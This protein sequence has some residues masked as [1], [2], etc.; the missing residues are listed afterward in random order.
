MWAI[1]TVDSTD[2]FNERLD[3]ANEGLNLHDVTFYDNWDE[4]KKQYKAVAGSISNVYL[5]KVIDK[6]VCI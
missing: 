6:E 3:F 1:L 4:A 5:M 2:E